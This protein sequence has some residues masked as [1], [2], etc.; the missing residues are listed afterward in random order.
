MTKQTIEE[1]E[2]S[3]KTLEEFNKE[4]RTNLRLLREKHRMKNLPTVWIHENGTIEIHF[5]NKTVIAE[6]KSIDR[7]TSRED[8]NRMVRGSGAKQLKYDSEIQ[9]KN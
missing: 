8:S 3:I 6:V 1:I 2:K 9:E 5:D 7:K 4:M